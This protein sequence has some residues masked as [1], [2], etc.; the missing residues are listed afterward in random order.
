MIRGTH[1]FQVENSMIR[2][3]VQ[4]RQSLEAVTRRKRVSKKSFGSKSDMYE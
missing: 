1:D 2:T 4:N 3:H